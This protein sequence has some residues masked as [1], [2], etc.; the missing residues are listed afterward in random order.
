VGV[1]ADNE[2][3]T[4]NV[5]LA[6]QDTMPGMANM[7]GMTHSHIAPKAARVPGYP[8]DMMMMSMDS[9]VAKPETYGLAPGWSSGVTG[10][11]TLVRVLPPDLYEEVMKRVSER[12]SG[13]GA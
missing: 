9:S 2:Q 6:S 4:A 3:P 11:T 10:M 12:A 13:S 7:Q 8:Q 1:G 5:P